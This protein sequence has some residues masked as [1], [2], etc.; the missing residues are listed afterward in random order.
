MEEIILI[1]GST[2]RILAI[3]LM[4]YVSLSF[5]LTSYIALEIIALIVY[6]IPVFRKFK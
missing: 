5:G 2:I 1:S 6:N 3:C 4:K